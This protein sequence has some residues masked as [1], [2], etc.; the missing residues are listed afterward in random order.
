MPETKPS[1]FK[2]N[3][4]FCQFL[5]PEEAHQGK[6]CDCFACKYFDWASVS[7]HSAVT[8]DDLKGSNNDGMCTR[9]IEKGGSQPVLYSLQMDSL[10]TSHQFNSPYIHN[11]RLYI[12]NLINKL[13]VSIW[14]MHMV[15]VLPYGLMTSLCSRWCNQTLMALIPHGPCAASRQM[16]W[17]HSKWCNRAPIA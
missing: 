12:Y 1:N 8:H 17:F 7:S 10:G 6:P 16:V 3:Y 2:P 9:S 5:N 4:A 14:S 13:S 15:H 11:V